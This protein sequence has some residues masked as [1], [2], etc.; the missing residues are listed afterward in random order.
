MTSHRLSQAPFGL[1]NVVA[2]LLALLVTLAS[3]TAALAGTTGGISGRATSAEDGKPLAGVTVNAVSPS[4]RYTGVTDASGFYS[5]AGVSPDTYTLSFQKSGLN[6][7]SQAGITVFA[8]QVAAVNATLEKTLKTIGSTVARA[9]RGAFQPAQPQDTYS[10]TAS[11]IQTIQGK[12]ASTDEKALLSRLPGASLD[13]NGLP[14]LRGGRVDE[15]GYQFDGIEQTNAFN[16][17]S[18][19]AYRINSSVGQLQ[20]TPGPGDAA[21][22]NAG[23]GVINL[24]AKR[25]TYPAFASLDLETLVRRCC[26]Y[27]CRGK[28]LSYACGCTTVRARMRKPH[29]PCGRTGAFPTRTRSY[30]TI[31]KSKR[32]WGRPHL[33][34]N[35]RCSAGHGLRCP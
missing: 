25:G 15:E 19:N 31:N 9:N 11:Q 16:G 12:S 32:I 13:I 1:R 26:P 24:V 35:R 34:T 28:D 22:G 21:S 27:E 6:A 8:D 29:R 33:A 30:D 5:F 2:L 3:V 7:F 4:A 20:L 17:V 23:T 18:N 10:V 14:V